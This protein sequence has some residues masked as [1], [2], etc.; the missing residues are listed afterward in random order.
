MK[1]TD[2][3]LNKKAVSVV[4]AGALAL[5]LTPAVAF[6][7]ADGVNQGGAAAQQEQQ[8]NAAANAEDSS[9]DPAAG[10][11]VD[12]TS[13]AN[14]A[15]DI[16]A[17]PQAEVAAAVATAA[18]PEVAKAGAKV[19]EFNG[20]KYASFDEALAVAKNTNGATIKLLVDA[21]TAGLNLNNDLTIDGN[22]HALKF[23][24][25]GIALWGKALTF[26]NV[27]VTMTGIGS[28]PYTAEWNWMSVSASKGASLTLD[29]ATLT[30]DGARTADNTHA[31]YFGSNNKLNLKNGSNLTIANYKQDAL[32]WDGGDGGYNVNIEDGST[33]I[34]DHNRS[35]F[36]G[37]FYA[38]IDSSTVKVLNSTGNGSNGTYFTIK[39]GSEVTFDNSGTWGISAWRI[40]MSNGSKLYANDNGY[41]GIW[42]RVLNVDSSC[43][44]DVEGNGTKG[45]AAKTNG[46]I[47]FQGNGK[48]A[49]VIEKG[50][51][52]TVT[53]NAGS[54][55]YTAQKACDL[56][57]GSATI[58]NNGTGACNKD[59]IGADM[60]GG[61]YNVGNMKLDRSVVI[62]NNHAANAG[63]DIYSTGAGVT[64]F[65][66]VGTDCVLDDCDHTIDGWY[67]DG[68]ESRW[69]AHGEAKYVEAAQP[70]TY[71][72]KETPVAFKAAHGLVSVDYQY[73]GDAPE[74]AALPDA[75]ADLEVG[76]AYIAKEQQ[77]VDGWT[78]DG[79][80]TDEDCTAKW[81][82]GAELATSMTL[83]GKWTKNA[84]P[85]VPAEP[86][87]P[88]GQ[89]GTNQK[90]ADKPAK[91][92]KT[93]DTSA[94]LGFGAAG[95]AVAAS[96]AAFAA[97]R[98]ARR[99]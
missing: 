74:S 8:A 71:E 15:S 70:G 67:A 90:K 64:D 65:G 33:Y 53:N 24:D 87:Q 38:T 20:T 6:A 96:A 55:I 54:G 69:S 98:L 60:G 77:P 75:D 97:R 22:G 5:S 43:L 80:Y 88:A 29:G 94:A 42:T 84:D 99:K 76:T 48:Y 39:N 36:T 52:V 12:S 62:Y 31:I 41:S 81:D 68:K 34:S 56:T 11:S 21:E 66:S 13:D 85:V 4:A 73:V 19:A 47:F 26:K 51:N 37:T 57:I 2:T 9:T 14:D 16:E 91:F 93:N 49:S 35:G 58:T 1:K 78:F 23:T 40:D 79:W 72:A 61:V 28:T 10:E 59:G 32:E 27:N 18:E 44:V 25:K 45:F 3:P 92:A 7:N 82:D 46:G 17:V 83:F 89:Q 30:M 95:A 86:T 63:D 50:A